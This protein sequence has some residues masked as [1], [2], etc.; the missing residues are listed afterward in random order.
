MIWVGRGR[1]SG[2]HLKLG[3]RGQKFPG[4][5]LVPNFLW[6]GRKES[7]NLF[8]FS[9]IPPLPPTPV[10]KPPI[11]KTQFLTAARRPSSL[12]LGQDWL[13]VRQELKGK[14]HPSD[15]STIDQLEELKTQPNKNSARVGEHLLLF[16]YYFTQPELQQVD[17]ISAQQSGDQPPAFLKLLH[18]KSE[19]RFLDMKPRR[20]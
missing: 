8:G 17:F 7:D 2:N 14:T 20:P 5:F 9:G 12:N 18:G 16:L 1:N 10:W 11:R 3:E 19:D 13:S 15:H 4:T 6:I